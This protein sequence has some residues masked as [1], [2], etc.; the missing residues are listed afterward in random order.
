MTS[1]TNNYDQISIEA[2]TYKLVHTPK[3]TNTKD[4]R[5]N[6]LP[7][8]CDFAWDMWHGP[9]LRVA[10]ERVTQEIKPRSAP[11]LPCGDLAEV[12]F[13]DEITRDL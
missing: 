2:G 5:L 10:D 4:C 13:T 7:S 1:M 3:S 12:G 6:C 11:F 8:L 9:T